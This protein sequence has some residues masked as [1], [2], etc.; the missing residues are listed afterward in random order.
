MFIHPAMVRAGRGRETYRPDDARG[1]CSKAKQQ[2]PVAGSVA[3][4]LV[5]FPSA[6]KR[7]ARRRGCQPW[8]GRMTVNLGGAAGSASPGAVHSVLHREQSHPFAPR[9]GAGVSFPAAASHKGGRDA[10]KD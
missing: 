4:A 10:R 3:F 5:P 8:P 1:A 7:R 6:A 2:G 9:D